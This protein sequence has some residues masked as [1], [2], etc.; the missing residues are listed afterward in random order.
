M[1]Q[2]RFELKKENGQYITLDQLYDLAKDAVI[3][4][5]TFGMDGTEALD[6]GNHIREKKNEDLLYENSEE[7]LN[8]QLDGEDPYTI[9]NLGWDD[10]AAYFTWNGWDINTTDDVWEDLDVDDIAEDILDGSYANY[11]TYEIKEIVA[12]YEEAKE[13]LE[14]LNPYREKA[15]QVLNDYLNC[16]ADVGDLLQCLDKLV[17]DD[18]AWHGEE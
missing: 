18:A 11:T 13:F 16:N 1:A 8:E 17:R 7:N 2:D 10:C 5:L 14:N 6:L 9:L 12:D 3:D 4:E 15:R